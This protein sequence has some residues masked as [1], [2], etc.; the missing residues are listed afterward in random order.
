M[1]HLSFSAVVVI[2]QGCVCSNCIQ[3]E[4]GTQQSAQLPEKPEQV[5]W[6]VVF[7][8]LIFIILCLRKMLSPEKAESEMHRSCMCFYLQLLLHL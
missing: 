3:L 8:I 6:D 1:A 4:P 5:L 2:I 7:Q